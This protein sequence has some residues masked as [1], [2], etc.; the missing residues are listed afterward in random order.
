MMSSF[1]VCYRE[2]SVPS[3][4]KFH[5]KGKRTMRMVYLFL[6]LFL[7]SSSVAAKEVFSG[8]LSE[9]GKS[10]PAFEL[11][12]LAGTHRTLAEFR[13]KVVLLNFWATW[14]GSCKTELGPLNT[15]YRSLKNEG[16]VVLAVSLDRSENPVKAVAA[17]KNILFPILIDRDKEVSFDQYAVLSLPVSFLIDRNGLITERLIGERDWDAPDMKDKILVLLKRRQ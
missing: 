11:P 4:L 1:N 12:D 14:C 15:L 5:K 7:I 6:A 8:E 16:F 17:E 9:A 13:G 10:A 3:L 2:G